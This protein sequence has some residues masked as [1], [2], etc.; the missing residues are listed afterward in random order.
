[1][2]FVVQVVSSHAVFASS[3][4]EALIQE[5]SLRRQASIRSHYVGAAEPAGLPTLFLL[6]LC[7]PGPHP[8]TLCGLLRRK[9]PG[10]KFVCLISPDQAQDEYML[11]LFFSGVEG[12]VCLR[13][14]WLA[15]LRRVVRNVLDGQ[16]CIP[17]LVLQNYARETNSL[18]E[19]ENALNKLLTAR[20]V[21]VAHL[22]LRQFST[23]AIAGELGISERTVKFHIA[24]IFL[25]TGAR[26]RRQLMAI[27]S[28][29]KRETDVAAANPPLVLPRETRAAATVVNR[30]SIAVGAND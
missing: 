10:C 1:M 21:Q 4:S 9:Y 5:P 12:I 23:R 28:R 2:R 8:G 15:E 27:V 19:A 25:K 29:N 22:A 7:C 14:P 6:D 11:N 26:N 18:L 16:L 3:V 24:N 20:E 17:P 30:R 13:Q